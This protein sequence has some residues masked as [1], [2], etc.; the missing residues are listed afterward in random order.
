YVALSYC[1][2]RGKRVLTLKST[3]SA[4]SYDL[5][6]ANLPKTFRDAIYVT[7]GLGYKY[8]WID[9]LCMVQDDDGEMSLEMAHMGD[10]YRQALFTIS[11]EGSSSS[12]AGNSDGEIARDVT[13][14]G[15]FNG[16]NYL[17]DR[18]W[19]LQEEVLSSRCLTFGEQ[20][21]W[22][23]TMRMWLYAAD[24][25]AAC[26]RHFRPR[27]NHF[28]TWYATV[29]QYSDKNLSFVS[30]TIRALS[31][32]ASMFSRGHGTTYL[33]GLW[34]EDLLRG[35]EWY[36]AYNDPREVLCPKDRQ[37]APSWSWASVGKVRI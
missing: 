16:K 1:W 31:G 23:C 17:K 5:R 12:N 15:S 36:V 14:A 28:D 18:G 29:E 27:S 37:K 21:G 10:I 8:L 34:K 19:I 30:D 9:A 32:L 22:R 7:N 35:L 26:A 3:L 4:H 11:T 2:G 33:A 6:I 24:R 13:L 20:M 25:M